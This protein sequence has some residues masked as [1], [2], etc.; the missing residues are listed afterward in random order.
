MSVKSQSIKVLGCAQGLKALIYVEA[1][2]KVGAHKPVF[3]PL[4]HC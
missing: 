3:S 2:G 1:W 4:Q